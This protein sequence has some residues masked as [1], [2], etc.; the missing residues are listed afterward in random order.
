MKSKQTQI[1]NFNSSEFTDKSTAVFESFINDLL[2]DKTT[3]NIALSGGST[4]LPIYKNLAHLKL[5]W[6]KINFFLVDERCVPLTDS[7]S[8][9]KNIAEVLF[10]HI[11]SKAF[12]MVQKGKPYKESVDNYHQLLIK[13][14]DKVNNI[15]QFD[16]MILGMGLDGHTASLFPDTK[17]LKNMSDFVVVN[18]VPQ[19]KSDR[20]TLTYPIL[21][22]SKKLILLIKGEEKRKVLE[23]AKREELPISKVTPFLDDI[24]N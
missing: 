14:L 2:Q 15:P 11:P 8:N 23:R 20:I 17:A 24:L 3:I 7:Q 6:D 5:P 21:I 9:Y 22:N 18:R 16:L 19:L 10:N 4:P 1:H 13:H 12:S